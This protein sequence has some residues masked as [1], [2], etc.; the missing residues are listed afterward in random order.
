MA[1]KVSV[2]LA[3]IGG[4]GDNY[5]LKKLI[6][7]QET[8][9]E[10]VATVDPSPQRCSKLAELQAASIPIYPTLEELYS[11]T[12]GIDLTIISSPIHF[13]APQVCTALENGSHVL[14]EKPLCATLREAHDMMATR[15]HVGKKVIIGYQWSFSRAIQT[16]KRDMISGIFGRPLRMKTLVLW[17]RTKAYYARNNW[18][19]AMKDQHGKLVLDSPVNNATAHFLHNMLY[20]AGPSSHLSAIPVKIEAELYRANAIGNY[21]SAMIRCRTSNAIDILFYSSHATKQA[22]GPDYCFE[23]E[24][25]TI[26]FNQKNDTIIASFKDGTRKEYGSPNENPYRKVDYAVQAVYEDVPEICGIEAALSHTVCVN[27]AQESSSITNFSADIIREDDNDSP[28]HLW[29]EGL[30]T[31]MES[32]FDKN[33]LPSDIA[34]PWAQK[35]KCIDLSDY[36]HIPHT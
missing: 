20:I 26:S 2:A 21:D 14:C 13:H 12:G 4:Y 34:V 25:A 32:C 27:G 35:G 9:F 19:G 24:N 29:V 7:A 22:K 23:C 31:T 3:G 1:K 11:Q 17:P 10:L 36:S 6:D 5:Y 33:C 18:A 16:L 15:D 28:S 8:R 30:D